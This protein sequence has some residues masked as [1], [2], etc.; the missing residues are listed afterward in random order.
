MK[1]RNKVPFLLGMH[2]IAAV[3]FVSCVTSIPIAVNHP[4]LMDTNG[5]ERLVIRPFEGPGN[6]RQ[7]AQD[8]TLLFR[9]KINRTGKFKVVEAAGYTPNTGMAD[10]YLTGMVTG[11]T[12]KD[13]SHSVKRT[14]K[15]SD[16]G[17]VKVEV[18]IYDRE[19][20]LEFTY[21]I[22]N[23]RDGTVIRNG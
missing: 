11:Y 17:T 5:I 16:G 13:G 3:F 9:E 15:T 18:P 12:V 19:V 10:A 7:I 4:P 14:Q 21:R 8:L 23:D 1:T 2:V 6:R 20:T 22:V